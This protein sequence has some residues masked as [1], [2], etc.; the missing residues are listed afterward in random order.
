MR[1]ESR[2]RSDQA[3]EV[4]EIFISN[5]ADHSSQ[6]L[7]RHHTINA[8]P[9]YLHD[10]LYHNEDYLRETLAAGSPRDGRI[11]AVRR[12]FC[13]F[14]TFDFLFTA[15]MWIICLV[16]IKKNN[17]DLLYRTNFFPFQISGENIQEML[18]DQIVHYTIHGSLFDIVVM[19]TLSQL[20]F[21]LSLLTSYYKFNF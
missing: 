15:L 13:L 9:N 3:R 12:F 17:F 19:L 16:V 1:K 5:S 8:M 14:V 18:I 20:S 6:S 11:S 4:A 10:S 7:T 21:K 2:N